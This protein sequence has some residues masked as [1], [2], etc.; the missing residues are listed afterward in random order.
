MIMDSVK[1]GAQV[2]VLPDYRREIVSGLIAICR[3][4]AVRRADGQW[5]LLRLVLI[6]MRITIGDLDISATTV[7]PN[8]LLSIA[9]WLK[10]QFLQR[11]EDRTTYVYDTD[12]IAALD[13]QEAKD[14]AAGVVRRPH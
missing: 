3:I 6:H 14:Q 1:E 13:A 12:L 8:D 9:A 11:I 4:D 7:D 10:Y 5:S 2:T